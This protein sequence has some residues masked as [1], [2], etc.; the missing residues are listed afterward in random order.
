MGKVV[1]L[2]TPRNTLAQNAI[3]VLEGCLDPKAVLLVVVNSDDSVDIVAGPTDDRVMST[4]AGAQA[5]IYDSWN[6]LMVEA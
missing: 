3:Q 4:L 6:K 2:R 1:N 5:L